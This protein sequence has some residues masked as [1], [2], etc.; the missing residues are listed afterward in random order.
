M[1]YG[2]STSVIAKVE[3]W[4]KEQ[5]ATL[6]HYEAIAAQAIATTLEQ[7][8][9]TAPLQHDAPTPAKG[10]AVALKGHELQLKAAQA[11][12]A[13]VMSWIMEHVGAAKEAGATCVGTWEHEG[14]IY[15]DAVAVLDDETQAVEMAQD[16]QQLAIYCLHEGR[17]IATA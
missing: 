14:V 4:K 1:S 9:Y 6:A 7:G 3:A 11:T 12:P 13:R 10:Y 15:L 2:H 8:G 5:A 16:H 17:E